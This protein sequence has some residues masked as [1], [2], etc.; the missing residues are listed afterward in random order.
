[1]DLISVIN[2]RNRSIRMYV[3]EIHKNT[4]YINHMLDKL[5]R[6]KVNQN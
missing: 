6:R 5:N 2:D 1:M 4:K 3:N